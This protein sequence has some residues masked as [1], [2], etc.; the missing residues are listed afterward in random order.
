[1]SDDLLYGRVTSPAIQTSPRL[2]EEGMQDSHVGVPGM[3][4]AITW[5]V[6]V[7]CIFLAALSI[8]KQQPPDSVPASAI[9][10][11]FSSGRALRHVEA[12]SR[13]ARPLGSLEHARVSN[14]ILGEVASMGVAPAEFQETTVVSDIWGIPYRVAKV[15]NILARLKGRGQGQGKAV[16]LASHYDSVSTGPGAGDNA[17]AVAAL[18][19]TLRALKA[20]APLKNDV[21]LLFTD[22]EEAGLLGAR[23]FVDEHPWAK[24][25]GIALNFDA[26]GTTGPSYMFQTSDQNGSLIQEFAQAAPHP[27]ASSVANEIYRLLPN[28]TDMTVFNRAGFDGLNFAYIDGSTKYHTMRDSYANVDE[29][30]LQHDG[31]YALALTRRFGNI[32]LPAPKQSNAVYFNAFG[33][34]FFHYP[35]AWV[36]PLTG[37]VLVLFMGVV[38]YGYKKRRLT[39]SGLVL[40]VLA[41]ALSVV[42]VFA[43]VKLAWWLIY[44]F[45][46][47]EWLLPGDNAYDANWYLLS[48]VALS[49]AVTAAIYLWFS[50]RVDAVNLTLGALLWWVVLMVVTAF[51]LSGGS[52]LLT[53]PLLFGLVGVAIALAFPQ[54]G[55]VKILAVATLCA[56]PGLFLL[57]P[58]IHSVGVALALSSPAM[59]QV[60]VVLLLGLLIPQLYGVLKSSG[61]LMPSVMGALGIALIIYAHQ[62]FK[63]DQDHPRQNNIF[64]ALNADTGK[65]TWA[66]TDEQVDKWTSGFFS[67]ESE[68]GSI[69]EYLPISYDGFLKHA[70]PAI[71]ARGPEVALLDDQTTDDVRVI[72]LRITSP[73]QAPIISIYVDVT[74]PDLK[75]TIDGKSIGDAAEPAPVDASHDWGLIYSAVPP[76]G[77]ELVLR[78]KTPQPLK[79]SVADRS[80]GLPQIP[81]MS[82]T[83]P[84]DAIPVPM[85]LSDTTSVTRKFIF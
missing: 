15:R 47:G 7:L 65:A 35:G 2:N 28:D 67:N 77:I 6:F 30:S 23:A 21:I 9:P 17:V 63:F 49:V 60:P 72:R 64:Y 55:R 62:T 61:W 51:Y 4:W 83:Y 3:S 5:S 58:M 8:Y 16:L 84:L 42:A 27:I 56:L 45:G 68:R 37:I 20:G 31:S 71:A 25:V 69:E 57:A 34:F 81:Q 43:V 59:L 14:Y 24:D 41:F 54:L 26:R 29:R 32:D 36:L 74:T 38:F 39:I 73:R 22:G 13:N 53:W 70:A 1:M 33:A 19:E 75:A 44:R 66:S 18:L 48:F 12:I 40:G 46:G 79:L 50:R 11:E 85:D 52:Y 80:F 76:G 78:M 82:T 10:T